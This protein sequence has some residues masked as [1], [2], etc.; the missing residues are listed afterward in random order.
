MIISHNDHAVKRSAE[1][2][3]IFDVDGTMYTTDAMLVQPRKGSDKNDRTS[4]TTHT[5]TQAHTHTHTHTP[6]DSFFTDGR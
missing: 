5:H 3:E 6:I 2:A 4:T 1:I